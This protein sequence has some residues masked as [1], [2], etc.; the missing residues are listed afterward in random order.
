MGND[1]HKNLS[2]REENWHQGFTLIELLVVITIIAILAALLLPV[3]SR[4]ME[5]ARVTECINNMRQ[6]A[7]AWLTYANDSNDWLAHNW[8][9]GNNP[10]PSWCS[11]NVSVQSNPSDISDMTNGTL[12]R[13]VVQLPV[14]HCPD[15]HLVNGQAEMRT[16]SMISRIAGA[17]ASDHAQYGVWDSA[18]SDLSG[19]LEVE[20]PMRK[21]LT[22][23]TSPSPADAIVFDDESQL[24]ID[25]EVLGLDWD[26]WK[27]SVSARHD[28]GCV[29]SF[30]DGHAERW[31]WLGLNTD[32]GYGYQPP[33]SDAAGWRDLRTFEA[34]VVTTNLPPN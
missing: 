3:L 31:Q 20:F 26:D 12:F 1:H 14:Y 2:A 16:V 27:N 15:A 28:R 11:G 4:S 8:A 10:P 30:A 18:A 32:E 29:F 9:L 24:T 19:D 7:L 33:M 5:Q 17:D 13:Y 34:A 22:E 25:D 6:L 23:F 21:K